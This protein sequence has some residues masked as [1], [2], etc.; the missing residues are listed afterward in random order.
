MKEILIDQ[1][2]RSLSINMKQVSPTIELLENGATIPFISRYR[3]EATGNLDEIQVSDINSE[4]KRLSEIIKRREY[5]LKSISDQNKLTDELTIK[6]NNCW[7]LNELEDIYLPF[8][9]KRKTRASIARDKGLEP[10]AVLIM[11]QEVH[12][13]IEKASLFLNVDVQNI[14]DALAG[15]RDIIAEWVSED[16]RVRNSLRK[17]FEQSA[18]LTSKVVAR[19]KEEGQ[20]YL[21]YFDY[22]EE[23]KNALD[24]DCWQFFVRNRKEY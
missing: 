15:T 19:K 9:P 17:F 10:L 1:I 21:D 7:E 5:I 20:K 23:L 6:I 14:D 18:I 22:S 12:N 11:S 13:L 2:S 3:K 4:L 16:I 24:T 8:K